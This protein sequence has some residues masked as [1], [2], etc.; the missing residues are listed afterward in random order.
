MMSFR[1]Q[2]LNVTNY[3][4]SI[5]VSSHILM[6]QMS[7]C[8]C[9]CPLS[10]LV[11]LSNNVVWSKVRRTLIFFFLVAVYH[12]H[13]L[14]DLIGHRLYCNSTLSGP[15]VAF[16][17][18]CRDHFQRGQSGSAKDVKVFKMGSMTKFISVQNGQMCADRLVLMTI[19]R[20]L[21]VLL[22]TVRMTVAQMVERVVQ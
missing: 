4:N 15:S 18:G 20:P 17:N 9:T 16:G 7:L 8:L 3:F 21:S 11:T 22:M 5:Q 13:A 2:K 12:K 14:T 1:Y 10:T 6:L 19:K